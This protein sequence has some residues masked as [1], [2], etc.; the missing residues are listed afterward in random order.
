MQATQLSGH[1]R[2]CPV[3]ESTTE[4][5]KTSVA[6]M[7]EVDWVKGTGLQKFKTV[8]AVRGKTMLICLAEY[9]SL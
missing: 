5:D 9:L 6:L 4:E 2:V 8:G 7:D 3:E 1:F